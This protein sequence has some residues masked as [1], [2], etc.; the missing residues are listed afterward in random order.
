MN[1]TEA[2]LPRQIHHGEM[3]T[4]QDG[5]EVRFESNGEAKDIFL[6]DAYTPIVQLFPDTE[7]LFTAGDSQYRVT[8]L[9]EDALTLEKV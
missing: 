7:Y 1:F 8:A 4:L 9:F 5:T 6:G 2:D 3:V